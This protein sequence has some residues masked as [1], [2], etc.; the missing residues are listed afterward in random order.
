[1]SLN[2]RLTLKTPFPKTSFANLVINGPFIL[3]VADTKET[4]FHLCQIIAVAKLLM[5]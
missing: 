4:H 5:Q 2:P 3:M 1:M